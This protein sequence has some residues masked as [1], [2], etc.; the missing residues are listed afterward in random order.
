MQ[1]LHFR[2]ATLLL[3]FS[4]VSVAVI[5]IEAAIVDEFVKLPAELASKAPDRLVFNQKDLALCLSDNTAE[6]CILSGADCCID[7]LVSL[8]DC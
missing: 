7:I 1:H 3:I 4:L 2:R 8:F 6:R 5:T